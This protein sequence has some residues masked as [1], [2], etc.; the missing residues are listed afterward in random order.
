MRS[1]LPISFKNLKPNL[2]PENIYNNINNIAKYQLNQNEYYD[3]NVREIENFEEGEN[4]LVQ[5]INS[6]MW[7]P[8]II[9]EKLKQP[10]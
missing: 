4:V 8:E 9:I 7:K 3:S 6:K 10:R 2:V 5:D 1:K